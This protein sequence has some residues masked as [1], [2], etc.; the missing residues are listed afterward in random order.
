MSLSRRQFLKSVGMAGAAAATPLSFSAKAAGV[1]DYKALVC[2]FLNGGNDFFHQVVATDDKHYKAFA[3]QR[4]A[5]APKHNELLPL[6]LTDKYGVTLGLHSA[7]KPLKPLFDRGSANVVLN[8]GPLL[9]P[10]NK[11]DIVNGR[12]KLPP[13]LFAHNKQQDVWQ[14]SWMGDEYA[15]QGWMG[16]S[17]DV[18]MQQMSGLPNS[19]YT[20]PNTLLDGFNSDKIYVNKNGFVQ[21]KAMKSKVLNSSYAAMANQGYESPL[22]AGYAEVMQQAIFAQHKMEPISNAIPFDSR[23][24]GT[25]FGAQ[26][27]AIKQMIDGAKALGHNRQVFYVVMN[28]FDTHDNQ[29]FRQSSLMQEFAEGI[30]G[31]YNA[32]DAD[33]LSDKVLTFTLSEFGRTMH[34]NARNG[35]DHGW[36][37]GQYMFGPQVANGKCFGEYP[38]FTRNSIDDNGDGRLIP[39]LSHEAYAAYMVQWF[40]MKP[41]GIQSVFPLLAKFDGPMKC[42]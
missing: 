14:H 13:Y 7:L 16:M 25:D 26:L 4:Q 41:A 21:L 36:G 28:G 40:G 15:E 35:T 32:L 22:V 23:I 27:R 42:V 24:P 38:D 29:V 18:L 37:G 30:A 8:V 33:G 9:A 20:G 12:A 34:D 1:Q 6:A 31:F 11:D 2:I 3:A 10:T 5:L 39:T 19:F 17:M